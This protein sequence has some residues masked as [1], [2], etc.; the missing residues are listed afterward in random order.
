M[1]ISATCNIRHL[2]NI[3]AR[4]SAEADGMER[5]DPDR[6]ARLYELWA[7]NDMISRLA[8]GIKW[9]EE[10]AALKKARENRGRGEE[11]GL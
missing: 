11:G 8:R 10:K 6:K 9:H 2:Q 5:T 3:A 4:L 1:A 7:V